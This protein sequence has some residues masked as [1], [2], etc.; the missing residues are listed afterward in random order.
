MKIDDLLDKLPEAW[1]P[2]AAKYGQ[3]LVR[4]TAEE[5]VAW[6][7]LLVCG[8]TKEAWTAVMG[9]MED[10]DMLAAG[11]SLADEW[12]EANRANAEKLQLQRDACMAVL[13]VLLAA[14]LAGVGL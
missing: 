10:P 5:F 8:R 13:R 11:Q 1:R 12:D 14:A 6:V 2:V 4:M 9:R 7:E 3:A